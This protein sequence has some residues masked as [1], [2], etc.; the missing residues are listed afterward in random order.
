MC[1]ADR[2]WTGKPPVCEEV[3]CPEIDPIPNS[4]IQITTLKVI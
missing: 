1:E 4:Q 3:F 2:T